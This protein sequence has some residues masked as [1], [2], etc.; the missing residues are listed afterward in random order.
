MWSESLAD[1]VTGPS[2]QFFRDPRLVAEISQGVHVGDWRYDAATALSA[3]LYELNIEHDRIGRSTNLIAWFR[4]AATFR[5]KTKGHGALTGAE[6]DA[7]QGVVDRSL[8]LIESNLSIF[9]MTWAVVS[10]S[11]SGKYR[12]DRICGAP[13]NTSVAFPKNQYFEDGVYIIESGSPCPVRLLTS[14]VD[15]TFIAHPNGSFNAK[16]YEAIDLATGERRR[17][18]AAT[19]QKPVGNLPKSE[20]TAGAQHRIEHLQLSNVPAAQDGYISRLMLEE[21]LRAKLS[22]DAFRV[23]TL[24][25]PGGIG[26][27]SLA[28][29]VA[30][31]ISDDAA[32]NFDSIVWFS[33]RDVDLLTD[34]PKH[35]Q[36]DVVKLGDIADLFCLFTGETAKGAGALD[37]LAS[38][39]GGNDLGATLFI[40][41]NFETVEAP[42]DVFRWVHNHVRAPNRVLITTR[43]RGEFNGDY[44]M[45][46]PGMTEEESRS[47]IVQTAAQLGVSQLM[48]EDYVEKLIDESGGHP[49]VM[50]VMIGEVARDGVAKRPRMA[51]AAKGEVLNALFERSYNRLSPGSKQLFLT[52]SAW[53]SYVP[54]FALVAAIDRPDRD[55]FDAEEALDE[56]SAA[57]LVDTFV[58]AIDGTRYV[59]LSVSAY[60]FG[61]Q[62]LKA[63]AWATAAEL[64]SR[65][66][67][68]FGVVPGP[69]QQKPAVHQFRAYLQS[70][71]SAEVQV[72]DDAWMDHV[73]F[74]AAS[75]DG[76]YL[77]LSSFYETRGGPE[78]VQRARDYVQ[79]FIEAG[80][81]SL[82]QR[83]A[84]WRKLSSLNAL[85][86]KPRAE[87]ASWVALV[88][89]VGGADIAATSEATYHINRLLLDMSPSME[90]KKVLLEPVLGLLKASKAKLDANGCSRAAWIALSLNQQSTAMLFAQHGLKLSPSNIHC[91]NLVEKLSVGETPEERV[92]R[93]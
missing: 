58:S 86:Q 41:D 73:E 69:E 1:A 80:A 70:L 64:D 22:H 54:E 52:M 17:L 36:P 63:S 55:R 45:K 47:L 59:G 81:G 29:A 83:V 12:A 53:R 3:V 27:T 89:E 60:A 92:W 16:G 24:L 71:A 84:A 43:V 14:T 10:R 39:L 66:L 75:V 31:A 65:F 15:R 87:L 62:K 76:G 20:S 77:E 88:K 48:T 42:G 67:R 32:T 74:L 4:L 5:N 2:A 57:S 25:G 61:Q 90:E 38:E 85:L 21:E 46:V 40:F 34:G 11:T 13:V 26:K 44:S 51:I 6:L 78:G 18:P 79:R 7:V 28:L 82:D 33:A 50:K 23:I 37:V 8:G 56:L 30:N 68:R 93:L 35:V 49:Y 19:F 9:G 72:D 91:R